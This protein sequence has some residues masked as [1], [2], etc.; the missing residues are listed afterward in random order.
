[1]T[2]EEPRCARCG[3]TQR[4]HHKLHCEGRDGNCMC[5]GGWAEPESNCRI[6][7]VTVAGETVP[8][9]VNGAGDLTAEGTAA[10]GE[11]VSVVATWTAETNPHAGVI[12]ELMLASLHCRVA[13]REA[14]RGDLADRLS[15]A[16][17]AAREALKATPDGEPC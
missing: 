8:V 13:L 1:V 3:C 6:V 12:Q 14:R 10:L 11:I 16:I 4:E 9:R 2:A 5:S 7:E 17:Q 15:A